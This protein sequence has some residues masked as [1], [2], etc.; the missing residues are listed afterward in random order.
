MDRLF[1]SSW[2]V[3]VSCFKTTRRL[4]DDWT[5]FIRLARSCC[6]FPV[7]SWFVSLSNKGNLLDSKEVW[8]WNFFKMLLKTVGQRFWLFCSTSKNQC[9]RNDRNFDVKMAGFSTMTVLLC[10]QHCPSRSFSWRT[11]LQCWHGH[12]TAWSLCISSTANLQ[13]D[14]SALVLQPTYSP[15]S[16]HWFYSHPTAWSLH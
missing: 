6:F 1:K 16:L 15:I 10:P 8:S 3:H 4:F 12:R 2:A 13:S 9:G 11:R 14:L 7:Q 5:W